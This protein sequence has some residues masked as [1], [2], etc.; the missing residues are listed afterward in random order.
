MQDPLSPHWSKMSRLG[1]ILRG[2]IL[3]H[4]LIGSH[5]CCPL[6]A[7]QASERTSLGLFPCAVQG[8]QARGESKSQIRGATHLRNTT[9]APLRCRVKARHTAATRKRVDPSTMA[10]PL[11]SNKTLGR[12]P[13]WWGE[14]AVEMVLLWHRNEGALRGDCPPV[15]SEFACLSMKKTD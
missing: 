13:G 15:R 9:L 1:Q 6:W 3:V 2:P 11:R 4:K 12:G 10:Q 5:S 7:E 8:T 14:G